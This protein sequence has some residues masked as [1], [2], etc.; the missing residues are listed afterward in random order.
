MSTTNDDPNMIDGL[1]KELKSPDLAICLSAAKRLA[2]I[3]P[4][5]IEYLFTLLR[6]PSTGFGA[7]QSLAFIGDAA[8]LPLIKLLN[9]PQT[10]SFAAEALR[11]IGNVS[12]LNLIAALQDTEESIRFWATSI[13]GW[14]GDRRAIEPLKCS[15]SD[16]SASVRR[17]AADALNAMGIV[18][19][20]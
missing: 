15:L 18:R 13:L 11:K 5:P 14:I 4:P 3:E 2:Q 9:D 6:N 19:K 12:V 20:G 10:D 1:V 16:E 17:A 7:I 8:V